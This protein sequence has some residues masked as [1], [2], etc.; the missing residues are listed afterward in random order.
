MKRLGS[1]RSSFKT[2]GELGEFYGGVSGKSKED[3]TE[4]NAPLITYMNVFANIEVRADV[5]SRVRISENEKQN[6]VQFGDVLFTGS[7]ETLYECGMSSVMTTKTEKKIYLNSFCFGYR[8]YDSGLFLPSFT[9]YLFRSEGIREQIIKT[10]SGVTRFNVSKKK[11]ACVRIP[12]PP[13]EV[14]Q[15]IVYELD[16]F[17]FCTKKL[18]EKLTTELAV[19]GKQFEY[20]RGELLDFDNKE[21]P[22][23]LLREIVDFRNGKGH[24]KDI[25]E[26]G[27]Y[28]VVNSKYIST[29]GEVKKFTSKQICPLYKDDILMVMSDLPNGRALAKCFLV[30]QD[31]KYSL[32]QRIGAFHIKSPAVRTRFLFHVLNR[33]RQLLAYDN[34]VEQTNLKKEE[35][36]DIKIYIPSLDVQDRLVSMLDQFD[37]TYNDLSNSLSVEIEARWKQY[38]FY[39]DSLLRFK[40]LTA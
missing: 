12:I 40:E 31:D 21:T 16:N 27:K 39:R 6:N 28:I 11:M 13:L 38:E 29:G 36:L 1:Q 23:T 24:E 25:D 10:A 19:R 26:N 5:S 8:F 30:D 32:N 3:F 9:K 37:S 34:G 14:Q 4:G 33:N 35:I 20:Y 17:T 22:T 15:Q 18:T 2:M 7:S